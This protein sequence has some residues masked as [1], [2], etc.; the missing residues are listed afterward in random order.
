[1]TPEELY[2]KN[3]KLATYFAKKWFQSFPEWLWEDVVAEARFG[4]WKAC[5]TFDSE[6]GTT[7]STYAE[8]VIANQLNMLYRNFKRGNPLN[9]L[10]L[11]API[12]IDEDGRNELTLADVLSVEVDYIEMVEASLTLERMPP[13]LRRVVNGETQY[14]IAEDLGI[15][16]A[17]VSRLIRKERAQLKK[18]L[19]KF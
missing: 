18:A 5:I 17:H 7:F 4:L 10:S 14:E 6:K 8:R 3:I 12:A 1:M 2:G 9:T 13:L 11:D 16:Q 15:S 19:K